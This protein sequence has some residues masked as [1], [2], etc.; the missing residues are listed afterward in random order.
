[1]KPTKDKDLANEFDFVEKINKMQRTAY[2][3]A[4]GINTGP[5]NTTWLDLPRHLGQTRWPTIY[6]QLTTPDHLYVTAR[7]K[8]Q[9]RKVLM[10][11]KLF[12]LHEN[13]ALLNTGIELRAED[14]EIIWLQILT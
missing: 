7:N 8:S 6:T 2:L 10:H 14:D 11:E 4:K 9:P 13:V 5:T 3:R 1:M 12:H